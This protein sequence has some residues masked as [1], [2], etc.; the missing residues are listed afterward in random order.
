MIK[1]DN[2]GKKFDDFVAVHDLSLNVGEG[3]LLALLGPNG[4]GKTTTVRMLSS[5]LKP[6]T[7]RAWVNGYDVVMEPAAVRRSIGMLTEQPGLYLRM[8]GMEYLEFYGRLYSLKDKQ[9]HERGMALFERFNMADASHRRLGQYSKGMRQKVGLIRTMLHDPAVL[10]LDEP[11]SAM[12]PHSAKLVRDAIREMRADK[13]SFILCTH[14]LAEAEALADRI[15]IIKRGSIV[16]EGSSQELKT[17]LLGQPQVEIRVDQRLNGEVKELADLVAVEWVGE[18][19]L[20]Y[21]TDT[22]EKD[23]PILV[24]RLGEL[25]LGIIS[26]QEVTQSLEDVYL[27]VVADEKESKFN[28]VAQ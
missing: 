5:I 18:N 22:P 3:E 14:N 19:G 25:G 9:I 6:T 24:R 1:A 27:R 10:L 4:A 20:R 2:L 26:V 23:N 13:R 28:E 15:A 16:A 11:T 8:T 21:R 17:Q 7:G 12:D